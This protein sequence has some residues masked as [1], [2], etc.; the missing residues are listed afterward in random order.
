MYRLYLEVYEHSEAKLEKL[1]IEFQEFPAK[2]FKFTL[3][4]ET[5][6]FLQLVAKGKN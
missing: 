3:N 2:I 1:P 4:N 5:I 6:A